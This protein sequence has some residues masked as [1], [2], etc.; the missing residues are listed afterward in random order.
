MKVNLGPLDS[1]ITAKALY[2]MYIIS[3]LDNFLTVFIDHV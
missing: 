2:S 1:I 3:A